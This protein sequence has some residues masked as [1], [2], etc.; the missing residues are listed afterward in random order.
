MRA[1]WWDHFVLDGVGFATCDEVYERVA[2]L[3]EELDGLVADVARIHGVPVGR[4]FVHTF[5]DVRE[6]DPNL[7]ALV[8]KAAKERPA[9]A[10][11]CGSDALTELARTA[12]E[13]NAIGVLNDWAEVVI[14][15]PDN[16]HSEASWRQAFSTQGKSLRAAV[17]WIP[18]VEITP[19][20]G[21]LEVCLQSHA[22]GVAPQWHGVGPSGD[23]TV[24]I[25]NTAERVGRYARVA[26]LSRPGDVLFVDALTLHRNGINRGAHARWAV[27]VGVYDRRE[28]W[29]A[30]HG[31]PAEVGPLCEFDATA[32]ALKT[33]DV[34]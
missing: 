4:S 33:Q 32:G 30:L 24:H 14:D 28:P 27:R 31:W 13:S 8:A 21:P 1:N 23:S 16:A 11:L 2:D 15:P 3:R 12:L 7:G 9:F 22:D 10:A 19:E 5:E 17:L 25:A 6:A 20:L 18:L 29:G 26:P 34:A